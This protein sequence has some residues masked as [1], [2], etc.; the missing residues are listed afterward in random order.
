M[1]DTKDLSHL[2]CGGL[3]R[4]FNDGRI[5]WYESDVD[6]LETQGDDLR[7]SLASGESVRVH[8]VFLATGF[9]SKRPGG[10]FVD[11]LIQSAHLPC[12]GCGYPLVDESLRWHPRVYVSGPLAEL[13]LGP[14]SRNIAGARRAGDRLVSALCEDVARKAS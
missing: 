11:E 5:R 8:R 3:R 1:L 12:A 4:A 13:E 10:T 7:V 14:S 9:E 2:M 6:A